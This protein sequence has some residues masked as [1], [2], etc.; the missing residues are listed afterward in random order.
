MER[1]SD[2]VCKELKYYVYRLV[3]PRNGQTFY[4]GKGKNNR[5]FAHVK[6]AIKK[7]IN[8]EYNLE[9]DDDDIGLKY[10]TIKDI[11]DAG[12][13]VINIIEKYGL[14]EAD[15]LKIESV[16]INTYSIHRTLTNKIKGFHSSTPENAITL[17]QRLS[18]KEYIDD[19]SNP[20]Y[21]IIKVNDFWLGQRNDRYET[22]RS[23]WKLKLSEAQKYP[24]V[25]SV[26]NGVVKE[27][28]K[29]NEWHYCDNR[30]GRIEFTGEVASSNIRNIFI[31]KKIPEK[32]R[33]KGQ[34][35]PCLYCKI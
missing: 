31:N 16:L 17:E 22:T 12:L 10:K 18:A 24:Y 3:D 13:E 21:I 14:D 20:K 35:S 28:Y 23:A 1:F 33:K 5:V 6:C 11:T 2:E 15:A 30:P 8:E 34:A 26:S 25:L 19:I 27:V 29:V 32:Y 7:G 4:V 9:E